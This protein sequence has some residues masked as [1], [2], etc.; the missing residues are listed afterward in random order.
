MVILSMTY[1]RSY[2]N[3]G[4]NAKITGLSENLTTQIG[5]ASII[6][7]STLSLG[8]ATQSESFY[9]VAYSYNGETVISYRGTDNPTISGDL[10][11]WLGGGGVLTG[12]AKMAA[13]FYN[14]GFG[15]A[16]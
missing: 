6:A 5:N 2:G 13:Q 11:D 4:Y 1:N 14:C 9:A 12:Q 7:N 15:T 10:D 8:V 16:C 3:R